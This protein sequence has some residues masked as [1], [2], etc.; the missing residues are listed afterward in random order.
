MDIYNY[1]FDTKIGI[2]KVTY[3]KDFLLGIDRAIKKSCENDS[4]LNC[5]I[6]KDTQKQI[7]EYLSKKRKEFDLPIKLIGTEFQIKVWNELR[8]IP[9]GET[10]SYSDIANGINNPKAIRAVGMANNKNP[11][12]IVVPCHRVIGKSGKMVGYGGGIELKEYLLKLENNN[13]VN[14]MIVN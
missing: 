14:G 5:E 2:L 6:A 4:F 9:Y 12:M 8:K 1:Y 7:N 13:I 3:N 10:C 11:I